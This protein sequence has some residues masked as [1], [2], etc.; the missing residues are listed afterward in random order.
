MPTASATPS[1]LVVGRAAAGNLAAGEV[2][3]EP[4]RSRPSAEAGR[5]YRLVENV[6]RFAGFFRQLEP[7]GLAVFG[8]DISA[9]VAAGP[10]YRVQDADRYLRSGHP[11][12]DVADSTPDIVDGSSRVT[13]ASSVLTDGDWVWR[14]DLAHYVERH[15]VAL[16]EPLAA[17]M[18]ACSYR[19][20]AV[21]HEELVAIS[22]VVNESLGFKPST[23]SGPRI[24]RAE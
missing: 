10:N 11:V 3:P 21:P 23:G 22:H 4:G 13:G 19:M 17:Q 24:R 8:D 9:A 7:D 15:N 12:L 18:R 1:A 6:V 14:W 20:P 16:P 2:Q 5:R